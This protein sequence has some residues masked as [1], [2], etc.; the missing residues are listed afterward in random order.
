[1][2]TRKREIFDLDSLR[3]LRCRLGCDSEREISLSVD[4]V[5]CKGG[6]KAFVSSDPGDSTVLCELYRPGF[7]GMITATG[8]NLC[9]QA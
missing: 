1:M 4:R 2:A 5:S 3:G 8:P 7:F 9:T 6:R